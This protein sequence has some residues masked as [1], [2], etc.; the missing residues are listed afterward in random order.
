MLVAIHYWKTTLQIFLPSGNRILEFNSEIRVTFVFLPSSS[1][2]GITRF[3]KLVK[4][5]KLSLVLIIN[6]R[7]QHFCVPLLTISFTF[8]F[9]TTSQFLLDRNKSE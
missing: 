6:N 8:F 9:R 5:S 7:G 4:S 1:Q 3:V 2:N